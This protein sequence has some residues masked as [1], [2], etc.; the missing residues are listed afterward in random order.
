[1]AIS[2]MD[3]D[4]ILE[5]LSSRSYVMPVLRPY[6]HVTSIPITPLSPRSSSCGSL[7]V[8]PAELLSEILEFVDLGSLG[9]L[10][11]TSY[12]AKAHV[13]ALPPY[14]FLAENATEVLS[15]LRALKQERLI[16]Y[17]TAAQIIDTLTSKRCAVCKAFG[18]YLYLL[19]CTR[20]CANCLDDW[21]V[22][23]LEGS[24]ICLQ[25]ISVSDAERCFGITRQSLAGIPTMPIIPCPDRFPRICTDNSQKILVNAQTARQIGLTL[26]G[27]EAGMESHVNEEYQ[28]AILPYRKQL[29][30]WLYPEL[31]GYSTPKPADPPPTPSKTLLT[32]RLPGHIASVL[33]PFFDT[34][35][36]RFEHGWL[37]DGCADVYAELDFMYHDPET[38]LWWEKRSKTAYTERQILRHVKKCPAAAAIA[39]KGKGVDLIDYD[40][41]DAM[42]I[43]P[44]YLVSPD[45]SVGSSPATS[46]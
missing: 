45:A 12:L 33:F 31:L 11:L 32:C 16:H 15:A 28:R 1:M 18:P 20:S 5:Q 21:D 10:R 22:G 19:S 4:M 14:R 44:P 26:Y 42:G 2:T 40:I 30:G 23:K 27:G 35:T 24:T 9:N 6:R 46:P 34:K 43:S 36:E 38:V 13:E 8:L 39:R 7:D 3:D 29:D 37:C 41:I 25:T 17:F